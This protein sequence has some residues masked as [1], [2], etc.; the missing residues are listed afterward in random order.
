MPKA[1]V[2]WLD[3]GL[4]KQ[5]CMPEVAECGIGL[6]MTQRCALESCHR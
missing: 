3:V 2:C 1:A 4:V 5:V 6:R